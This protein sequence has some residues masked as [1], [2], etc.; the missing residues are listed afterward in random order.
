MSQFSKPID[1][2]HSQHVEGVDPD[3]MDNSLQR[4]QVSLEEQKSIV[5]KVSHPYLHLL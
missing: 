5:Q 4:L 3:C 2:P 1:V